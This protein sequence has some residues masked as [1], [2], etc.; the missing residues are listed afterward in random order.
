MKKTHVNIPHMDSMLIEGGKSPLLKD[1]FWV[2]A[3]GPN[4]SPH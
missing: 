4:K 1:D 2:E 3:P